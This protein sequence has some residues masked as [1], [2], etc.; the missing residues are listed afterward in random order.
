M[1]VIVIRHMEIDR[2]GQFENTGNNVIGIQY[3]IITSETQKDKKKI[4]KYCYIK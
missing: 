2:H 4:K 3:Y 1:S